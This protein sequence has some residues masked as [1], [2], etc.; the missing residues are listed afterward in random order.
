MKL[1]L[2]HKLISLRIWRDRAGQDMV[3]Y[4]LMAGF[5]TVAVAATFP[6]VANEISVIFSKIQ[7]LTGQV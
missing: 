1:E 4:A 7:S 2:V 3:E 6:P 5:I